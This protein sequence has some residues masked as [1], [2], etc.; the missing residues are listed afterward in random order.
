MIISQTPLRISLLGGGSDMPNFYTKHGGMVISCAIDK[1]IYVIIKERFDNLIVL[2]YTKHEIVKNVEE[3]KHDLIRE[4]LTLY[5]IK[6]GIEITTL[7]DIPSEGSGLGSS[8][9]LIVGLLNA[10]SHYCGMSLTNDR[11]A[12]LACYVEITRLR[13]PIGK[14]DQY[15]AS[16]G[17][18]QKLTFNT[19]GYVA[20]EPYSKTDYIIADNLFLHYTG[21]TRKSESILSKQKDNIPNKAESLKR[22]VKMAERLDVDIRDGNYGLIGDYLL[23]SWQIKKSLADGISNPQIDYMT[24]HALRSGAS[25][26]KICGAG[27]GGFILSYVPQENHVAFKKGMKAYRELPFNISHYGSRIIFNIL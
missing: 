23:D 8:S 7:A 10:L 16:Y 26:V 21:I 4:C 15:I 14:Q 20:V 3:I 2:N 18:M 12:D 25:G 17:G 1:Y 13:K 22:L 24:E 9:S 6:G 5:N 27:G 11:L 19:E